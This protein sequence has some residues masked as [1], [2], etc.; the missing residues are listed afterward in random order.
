MMRGYGRE[1]NGSGSRS[2]CCAAALFRLALPARMINPI[3][4][5][6][7]AFASGFAAFQSPLSLLEEGEDEGE[8][9]ELSLDPHPY[10]PPQAGEGGPC[11]G[12]PLYCRVGG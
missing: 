12:D 3:P 10:P 5:I 1:T 6:F 7:L 8:G 2:R 4:T 11:R 9:G